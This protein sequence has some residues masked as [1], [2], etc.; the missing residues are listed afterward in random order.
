MYNC[1]G[2]AIDLLEDEDNIFGC[3]GCGVP[4]CE[5]CAINEDGDI[6]CADC[7]G[8]YIVFKQEQECGV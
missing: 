8:T 6:A 5:K 2:C 7:R 4:L 3:M 1:Y